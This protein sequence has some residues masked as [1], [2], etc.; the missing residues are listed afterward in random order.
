[1]KKYIAL[2]LIFASLALTACSSE[3]A[4]DSTAEDTSAAVE[5][6]ETENEEETVSETTHKRPESEEYVDY[7]NLHL[8]KD[9]VY[10]S[11]DKLMVLY[12]EDREIW[13]PEDAVCSVAYV[14]DTMADSIA[15]VPDMIL[16]PDMLLENG[17]Y[18]GVA[19]KLEQNLP[20]G[21]YGIVVKFHTYTCSFDMTIQ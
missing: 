7:R 13:Y 2:L 11:G 9:P 1:M 16:Y 5:T 6:I 18:N 20:A 8:I 10:L 15:A 19:L 17:D 12:F 3:T 4:E 21:D 14:S